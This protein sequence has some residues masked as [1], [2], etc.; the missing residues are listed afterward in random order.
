MLNGIYN[1]TMGA[2]VQATR[3]SVI[4]NNLANTETTGYKPDAA[5]FRELPVET[6]IRGEA[7]STIDPILQKTGGGVWLDRVHTIYEAGTI[8]ESGSPFT[9]AIVDDP[10]SGGR[11]FFTV[12][13]ADGN[14]YY[15][16]DGFFRRNDAGELTMSDGV[17][18]VLDSA[19]QPITVGAA[20]PY[21]RNDGVIVTG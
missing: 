12:E 16:R 20:E 8:R 4:A 19:G 2:L 14:T 17:T 15:T 13:G 1:S 3:H 18:R 9:A 5:V 21:I 10:E 7:G 11:G 6:V